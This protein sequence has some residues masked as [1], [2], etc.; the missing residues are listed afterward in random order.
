VIEL[1]AG[2]TRCDV[3]AANG[4]R[5][6]ALN[7]DGVD[8]IVGPDPSLP[9]LGWGS[10]P[11]VPFIGRI[12]RGTFNFDGAEYR[13]PINFEPHA[14]HG[15]GFNQSWDVVDRHGSCVALQC[16]LDWMFGGS[17]EQIIDLADDSLTC[18]LAVRAGE[19]PMPVSIGWHPW[20][21]KPD[22]VDLRFATMYVRDDDYIPDGRT[23]SPPPPPPWDDCFTGAL[24]TPRIW[25]GGWEVTIDSD[26]DNWVVYDM[27]DYGTCVEPQTA[28]ADAF[29]L[30][31]AHRLEPGE[32]LRRTM[33]IRW[34]R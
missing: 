32:E 25:I 30:G 2:A 33:T 1:H 9:Q 27:P 5:V 10:Y 21:T 15:T 3:D 16:Q 12:R 11:M 20:F 8:L 4:G 31:L 23:V 7:V 29:N 22:R 17:S 14:I 34:S 13:M 6:A 18:T 26:C 24:A 19:V 28:P